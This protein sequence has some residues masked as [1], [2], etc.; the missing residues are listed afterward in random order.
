MSD[1]TEAPVVAFTSIKTPA[2]FT[3]NVTFRQQDLTSAFDIIRIFEE[4]A[5]LKNWTPVE[6]KAGPGRPFGSTKP[7]V[8][9]GPA[10][11]PVCGA[12]TI[13]GKT[14]AGQA[15]EKCETQKYNFETKEKSGCPH[16]KY[17]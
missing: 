12:K 16:F 7:P 14:K 13:L 10:P 9:Y 11:C 6:P 3:W 2:G 4:G 15:F 8:E 5:K 17:L 1:H